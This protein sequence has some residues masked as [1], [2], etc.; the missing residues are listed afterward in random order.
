MVVGAAK[1]AAV[2]DHSRMCTADK[3]G[4]FKAKVLIQY[5]DSDA[6]ID[7]RPA[8]TRRTQLQRSQ[9]AQLRML[10]CCPVCTALQWG[11][12]SVL[13]SKGAIIS[14]RVCFCSCCGSTSRR[15][16]GLGTGLDLHLMRGRL[17]SGTC[18][19]TAGVRSARGGGRGMR[20]TGGS[21]RGTAD[22]MTASVAKLLWRGAGSMGRGASR[23]V[24]ANRMVKGASGVRGTGRV[25]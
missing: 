12:E 11:W 14:K 6:A 4:L 2:T 7:G 16:T 10:G 17:M 13:A 25:L 1:A 23:V 5:G 8:N 18:W 24:S 22:R 9:Y 20:D 19:L 15:N 3:D 21:L